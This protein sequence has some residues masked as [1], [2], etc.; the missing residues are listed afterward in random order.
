MD[1][2]G[3]SKGRFWPS[4]RRESLLS[5]YLHVFLLFFYFCIPR[6]TFVELY[7]EWEKETHDLGMDGGRFSLYVAHKRLG[8]WIF[9]QRVFFPNF[10]SL[11]LVANL[12]LVMLSGLGGE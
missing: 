9:T 5:N 1:D 2:L 8:D 3:V 4:S 10:T 7:D 6:F 12:F 11:F